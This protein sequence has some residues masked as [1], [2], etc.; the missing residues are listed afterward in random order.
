MIKKIKENLGEGAL[1][2]G[3]LLT[4]DTGYSSEINMEYLYQEKINAVIPDTQFRQRDPL[5]KDSETV[6][7][8]KAHRQKT[9]KDKRKGKLGYS[10]DKFA[11][12]RE[13]KLCIC[14]NGHEMMYH[15]DHFIIN[16]K[17]YLRFKSYLKTVEPAHYKKTA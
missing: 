11:L 16:N 10:S 3:T 13:A 2:H 14:P 15:G 5:F 4:A 6:Q 8:H 12:N 9:R 17:R 7:K 1:N